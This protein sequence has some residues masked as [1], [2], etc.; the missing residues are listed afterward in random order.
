MV[1]V[2]GAGDQAP[3]LSSGSDFI[4][5]LSTY[6]VLSK[7]VYG[8]RRPVGGGEGD[9]DDVSEGDLEFHWPACSDGE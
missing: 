2:V 5:V 4:G 9:L 7:G 3:K 8:R 1:R 6:S